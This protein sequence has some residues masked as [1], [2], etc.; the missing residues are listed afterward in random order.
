VVGPH[1]NTAK[2]LLRYPD[3]NNYIS[4]IVFMGGSTTHGNMGPYA[5]FNIW[6]DAEALEVVIRE[7]KTLGI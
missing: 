3:V 5:E 4:R 2:L 6:V 1:T 7:S